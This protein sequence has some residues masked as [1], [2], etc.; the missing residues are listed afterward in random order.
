MYNNMM[1]RFRYG[2]VNKKGIYLDETVSRMCSTHRNMFCMLVQQL[3]NAMT[4]ALLTGTTTES[5]GNTPGWSLA[6]RART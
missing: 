6:T 1:N 4:L 3:L 2:N 5:V